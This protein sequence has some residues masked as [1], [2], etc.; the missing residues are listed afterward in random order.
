MHT[1]GLVLYR[2]FTPRIQIGARK[3][4]SDGI[5]HP[6]ITWDRKKV[7]AYTISDDPARRSEE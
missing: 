4:N 1:Q 6:R 7:T 5:A 3:I 2:D